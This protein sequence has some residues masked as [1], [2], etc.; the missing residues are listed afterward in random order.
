MSEQLITVVPGSRQTTIAPEIFGHFVEFLGRGINDG[1]WSGEDPG[2][3]QEDCQNS[4]LP[5]P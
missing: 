2:I 5:R 4:T 3:P 1:V